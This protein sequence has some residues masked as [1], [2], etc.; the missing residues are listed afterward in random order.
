MAGP[1]NRFPV[2]RDSILLAGGVLG[3]G[4]QQVTGNVSA[5]L[6]GAYMAMLGLPTVVNGRWLLKT[7][8]E[9]PSLPPAPAASSTAPTPPSAP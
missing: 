3:I 8:G 7:L 4:Y 1:P 9:S 5:L 2:I 6:I